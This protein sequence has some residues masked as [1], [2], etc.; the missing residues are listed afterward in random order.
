M[1]VLATWWSMRAV[2]SA[3]IDLSFA[4]KTW[5]LVGSISA[6]G[7]LAIP[8]LGIASTSL[9]SVVWAAW[10]AT[11]GVVGPLLAIDIT[12]RRL[13]RQLSLPA[14]GIVV[15]LLTAANG[16]AGWNGPIIGAGVMT[17]ITVLLRLLSRGSLGLGDVL[18]S[19][20]LG[21][22]LGWFDPLL[23][24]GAWVMTAAV[25]GVVALVGLARGKN[26]AAVIAYGPALF[27]GSAVAL[28][29]WA[30]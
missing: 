18:V 7:A 12:T 22:A 21:A 1:F 6:F 10:G 23:V 27:A 20:L 5:W 9:G 17:S 25:G 19:P 8:T 13:P 4:V 24:A 14:F 15:V 2:G 16:P 30:W 29:G 3:N 28:V 26:R 11:A